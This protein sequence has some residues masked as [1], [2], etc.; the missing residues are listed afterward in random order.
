[1]DDPMEDE[2]QV[3]LSDPGIAKKPEVKIGGQPKPKTKHKIETS[4]RATA[5]WGPKDIEI[6]KEDLLMVVKKCHLTDN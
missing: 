3:K 6:Y 2:E 5:S 4:A 1:M